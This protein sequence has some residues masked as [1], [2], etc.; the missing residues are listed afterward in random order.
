MKNLNKNQV[1]QS[2]NQTLY[3][4]SV[5]GTYWSEKDL[6]LDN[7]ESL[8]DQFDLEYLNAKILTGRGINIKNF[9]NYNAI[10]VAVAHD[11]YKKIKIKND[12]QVIF[13]LKSILEFHDGR[14]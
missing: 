10:I 12:T 1:I 11:K 4:K 5:K 9:N 6:D 8:V 14:L 7:I 2:K 13:D 3:Y